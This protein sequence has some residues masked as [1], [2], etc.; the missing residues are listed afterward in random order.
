[1]NFATTRQVSSS[2][3]ASPPFPCIYYFAGV[4]FD[5]VWM[6]S[7]G[8]FSLLHYNIILWYNVAI[9]IL[10]IMKTESVKLG[11]NMKRI[12]ISKGLT[13]GDI[14]RSLGVSRGFI[15]NIESGKTN[16][17]LSTIAKL[18]KALGVSVD[19]LLK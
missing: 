10:W 1:M 8:I 11:K 2:A 7:E 16:P 3:L 6:A 15:S 18:A 4:F 19:K 17:T 5:L 13:Q 14:F 12:R 9:A